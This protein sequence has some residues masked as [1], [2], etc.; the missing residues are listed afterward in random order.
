MS[1]NRIENGGVMTGVSWEDFG[2]TLR[3]YRER[4][5]LSQGD[6]G[7]LVGCSGQAIGVYEGGDIDN[8]YYKYIK[9]IQLTLGIPESLM[10]GAISNV[11]VTWKALEYH[12]EVVADGKVYMV[13]SRKIVEG[14]RLTGKFKN[15]VFDGEK[16]VA[17]G[18]P[19]FWSIVGALRKYHAD[20][21][22]SNENYEDEAGK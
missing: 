11:S 13:V 14:D 16:E 8:A 21:I 5:Q 6:L 7:D 17:F 15:S 2:K 12:H 10:P 22:R 18:T 3:E 20:R 19:L 4:A 9:K 1:E